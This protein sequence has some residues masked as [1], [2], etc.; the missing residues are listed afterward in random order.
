MYALFLEGSQYV[1]KV[2]QAGFD[3][4]NDFFGKDFWF[5]KIVHVREI[6]IFKPEDIQTGF[7]SGNDLVIG[8]LAKSPLRI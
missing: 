5:R 6:G 1:L 7:V 2:F 3:I 4:L 8:V